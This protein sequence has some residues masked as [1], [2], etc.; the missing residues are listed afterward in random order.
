MNLLIYTC[1]FSE[2]AISCKLSLNILIP[3]LIGSK[4]GTYASNCGSLLQ[5]NIISGPNYPKVYVI[6]LQQLSL[7]N[8]ISGSFSSSFVSAISVYGK[9]KSVSYVPMV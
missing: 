2:S 6:F 4:S 7:T 5:K 1:Y 3:N 9:L 8:L